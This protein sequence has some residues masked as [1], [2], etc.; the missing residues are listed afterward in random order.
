MLNLDRWIL[1]I[2]KKSPSSQSESES[3]FHSCADD[4]EDEAND[5]VDE[6]TWKSPAVF[7]NN[8]LFGRLWC[9][10][11]GDIHL[12]HTQSNQKAILTIK[13]HSWFATQATRIAEMF[14]YN[15][16]IYDG[17]LIFFL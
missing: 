8:I 9:E 15:G 16:F 2:N 1:R 6:Y 4:V 12:K 7:I 17:I 13:T 10:F 5:I 14:K 3:S 11:Q